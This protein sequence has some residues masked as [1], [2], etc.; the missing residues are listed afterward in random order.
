MSSAELPIGTV[1]F[2]FTDI[3]GSTRLLKQV[4]GERYDEALSAHRQILREAFGEHDG[5]EIDTQGDSFFVA[6]RRAKD[7]VAAAVDC[8]RRLALHA[9][10]GGIELRVR[11]GIH[12]GE[13]VVGAE[14]YVGL[15][16]H[17]AARI[18]AAGHGGQ[19]LLSQTTREL[20]RDDPIPDVSVRD[21][22]EHQLKDMDEPERVYQ[23]VAPGLGQDFPALKT[24][25]P[26]PFEGREGELAEA[27]SEEMARRWRR[28]AR[29][30]L[31]IATF[32]AAALGV[33]GGVLLTRGGG[34]TAGAGIT[35]NAVGV[36]DSGSGK[37]VSQVPVGGAPGEVAVGPDAVWV[38]NTNDDTVSR[39][40]PS[41]HGIRQT[42]AVGAGPAGVAVG[43]GAV[44]V[45]NGLA[46][47]VSRIDPA[48]NRVV[49]EIRAGN[50]PRGV[51]YG[52]GAVWV[53]N[54]ADGT[55][56]RIDPDAE[57]APRTFPA[58]IGAAGVAVGFHRVW[59]AS[60][61]TATLVAL[62]PR[63]GEVLRR[64]GVGGEPS[65]IAVG[66]GAVWVANRADGTVSRIDPQAAVVTNVVPVGGKPG[67]VAAG[68][69]EVW[70][71][72]EGDGTLVRLDSSGGAVA[73]SETVAV[74][75]P[76]SS[77]ALAPDGVYVAVRSSGLEHR[78]GELRVLPDEAVRSIDPTSYDFYGDRI[79]AMTNDGLVGFRR[80]AGGGGVQLVPDLAVSIPTPTD[81]GRTYTFQVRPGVH[82]SDGRLVQPEDFKRA[83]ER[84][85][86]LDGPDWA[87]AFGRIVGADRCVARKQK[88]CK[89][90]AGI[91]ADRPSRTVTFKLTAPDPDFLAR[92]ALTG[93]FAVPAGTP[94]H[95]VGSRPVPATGPYRVA[96]FDRKAKL[97][98]LVRNE[99]FEEWS[100]DAQPD[101]LPDRISFSWS[102]LD[103]AVRITAVERGRADV[104]LDFKYPPLMKREIDR[105]AVRYPSRLHLNA[106]L[107]T[108][109]YWLNLRVAPFD[110]LRV[111]RAVNIA[112][113]RDAFARELGR[114]FDP[115]CRLLPPNMPG[116]QPA[117][118]YGPGGV[119][120]L[121]AARRLVR[122]SGTAG[123]RVTVWT[124]RAVAGAEQGHY[125][126]SVL[127]SLGYRAR[128]KVVDDENA[129][130]GA[131]FAP[132]TR[133]QTGYITW[134]FDGPSLAD[135]LG[136]VFGCEARKQGYPWAVCDPSIEAQMA[137]A[138]AVQVRDPPAA[139]PLWHR[140]EQ[141]LLALAPVVPTYTRSDVIFVSARVQNY[142]FNPVSGVLLDQLWVR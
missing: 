69:A 63:S 17:R 71:A 2:L 12:T 138:A 108:S 116:Y 47:T 14:R 41:T 66:A 65:A 70:V 97:V 24:A 73:K 99:R 103:P 84:A 3:E 77:V 42:I 40:D 9:W 83:I 110:D 13:P 115:T 20:L 49:A 7:A 136:G 36:V 48:T 55:V 124:F 16:V 22:G 90:D 117:C 133:I 18:C 32:A 74:D 129:Y 113:D 126:V 131:V 19:V 132:R 1:T 101:G 26:P 31:V 51:A 140:A 81:A 111:R 8:Q 53:T 105:L 61:P 23:L 93:A 50:G 86:G 106:E 52:E 96:A 45:A 25:A 121:D 87:Y 82:Y 64:I 39:I 79:L 44:W 107:T 142:R 38:T 30:T 27:A 56:V 37:V 46:G 29:R 15:G 11:M 94:A 100:G 35:A 130:F 118:P 141:S 125:L 75:N 43:G 72:N 104:A 102:R 137:H 67:D 135:V 120:A 4:G 134:G 34:S 33:A 122:S 128:L 119:R 89:L 112:F 85:L 68:G 76:P 95:D 123:A 98:R 57:R 109:M 92:L 80:V 139:L 114:A 21:L 127:D 78:G 6:F 54:S 60:P 62:D 58:V 59:V 28:P 5:R 10:P 91:V 88:P